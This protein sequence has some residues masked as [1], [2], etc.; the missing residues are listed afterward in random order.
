MVT[1]WAPKAIYLECWRIVSQQQM[2]QQ[3]LAQRRLEMLMAPPS[4]QP[5]THYDNSPAFIPWHSQPSNNTVQ[6]TFV[7]PAP[8]WCPNGARWCR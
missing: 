7:Q 6:P 2:Q 3:L 8:Q 4:P 1:Q 5:E